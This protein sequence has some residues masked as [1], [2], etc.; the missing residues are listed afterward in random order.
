MATA[1]VC[2]LALPFVG[3]PAMAAWPWICAASICNVIYLGALGEAY[4][5]SE[6]GM[7]YAVVRAVV[8]PLLFVLGWLFLTEPGRLSALAGLLLV[9]MSLVLFAAAK[10]NLHKVEL[11]SLLSSAFAGLVLAL[12]LL[13]DVKGIR[14]NGV[15]AAGLLQYAAA[16][17]LTTA[18]GIGLLSVA[19]RGN[20]FAVLV[21]NAALCYSGAALLLLSYL[22]GMWAYAQGPIGLVAP[23]RESGI[24]FSG[25]LAVLVL[26]ERVTELQWAAMGLSF[27]AISFCRSRTIS[28]RS[29]VRRGRCFSHW[30]PSE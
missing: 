5:H 30:R 17:S 12:A 2:T 21:S 14:E 3:F 24:L 20:P 11:P 6:F 29:A 4:S 9:V 13:F 27:S 1:S 18:A 26:R 7:V 25:V 8:P 10:S 19:R 23:V 16:S 22:C 28:F 15:D